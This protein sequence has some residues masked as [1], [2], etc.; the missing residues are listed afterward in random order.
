MRGGY[1]YRLVHAY[2][3]DVGG[4]NVLGE[5]T[6]VPA[7]ERL[8]TAYARLSLADFIDDADAE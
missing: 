3:G 2:R 5:V 1:R 6:N 4:V 8:L 7:L